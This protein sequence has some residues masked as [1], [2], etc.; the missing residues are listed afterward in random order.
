MKLKSYIPSLHNAKILLSFPYFIY[1][2]NE[3]KIFSIPI[4]HPWHS[5]FK[6]SN[7]NYIFAFW[8]L[9]SV[10]FPN[11]S[12][13]NIRIKEVIL[14][15]KRKDM[16]YFNWCRNISCPIIS[17]YLSQKGKIVIVLMAYCDIMKE[18]I[19]SHDSQRKWHS[20]TRWMVAYNQNSEIRF[21][22]TLEWNY[23]SESHLFLVSSFNFKDSSQRFNI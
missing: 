15:Q 5:T 1:T 14:G 13:V 17:H 23:G 7:P 6:S 10:L 21:F 16:F 12:L 9:Y 3:K 2:I 4:T 18:I 8:S 20:L 11:C 19:K 22:S